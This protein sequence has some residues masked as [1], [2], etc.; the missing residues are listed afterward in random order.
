MTLIPAATAPAATPPAAAPTI[1]S[2]KEERVETSDDAF[3]N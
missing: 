2:T 1:S 3:N